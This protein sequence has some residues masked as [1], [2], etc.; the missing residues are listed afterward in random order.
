MSYG[1]VLFIMQPMNLMTVNS[2]LLVELLS[3]SSPCGIDIWELLLYTQK[4]RC[5]G[6]PV[7]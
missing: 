4:M 2:C 7:S 5:T 6:T 3:Y 1:L